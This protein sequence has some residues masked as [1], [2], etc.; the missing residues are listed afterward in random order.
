[1][2]DLLPS[3][4]FQCA[5]L[6]L[7]YHQHPVN[8]RQQH[9]NTDS[10]NCLKCLCVTPTSFV[11]SWK[12]QIKLPKLERAPPSLSLC[13]HRASQSCGGGY[14]DSLKLYST[15]THCVW[16]SS[17]SV[18]CCP[19]AHVNTAAPRSGLWLWYE[20]YETWLW[21]GGTHQMSVV[22]GLKPN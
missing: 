4:H 11:I 12:K 18:L 6:H 10:I 20:W 21:H 13:G 7:K 17:G 1:M 2:L 14:V 16:Q 19:P 15:A 3:N 5:A 22:G 9:Y 8:K